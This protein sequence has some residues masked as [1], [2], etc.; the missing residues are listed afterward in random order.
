ML[1]LKKARI[2][3]I[4]SYLPTRVLLNRELEK[5]VDTTDEWIVQRTGIS[6]RH[7]AGANEAS[8]EMGTKA[9]LIA[10]ERAQ[11]KSDQI[12][13]ILVATMSPD[14]I[15]PSSACIIQDAIGASN[16]AAIDIQA[17]CTG[18]IYGLSMAKAYIESGI[19]K[20]ILLVASEKMSSVTDYTDRSTCILFGDGASASV[21]T[22]QGPG[23]EI[24]VPSLGSDGEFAQLIMIPAGGSLQPATVE[25]VEQRQHYIKLNGKEVFKQAVRRMAAASGKCLEAAGLDKSQVSWLVPHQAN[26][27][28]ID[29][30]AR[31]LE[32]P[33]EKIF[34][35]VHKYGN[36][37]A[38]S[39]PIALDELLATE[40]LEE[41]DHILLTA[42]GA[43]LT[44][45]SVILTKI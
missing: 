12:D 28:I 43:G 14:Y 20:T 4:G 26:S 31:S 29:A 1:I 36:T 18:Y 13:L 27:R 10:L 15:S 21:I 24:G 30:V 6:E 23:Y 44:W 5:M 40:K 42:F 11:V 8:S 25:S 19:Y 45:G 2:I 37:S 17:A 32:F 41:G 9:A 38:S 7:I 22:D 39:V 34:K 16:A 33:D 35:T 3:G